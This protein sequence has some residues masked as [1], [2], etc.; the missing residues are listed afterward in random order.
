MTNLK[1]V[2]SSN[3]SEDIKNEP[4]IKQN[5]INNNLYTLHKNKTYIS[6]RS[7]EK[8]NSTEKNST[9]SIK[10]DGHK[11]SLQQVVYNLKLKRA[12]ELSVPHRILGNTSISKNDSDKERD[13]N[14]KKEENDDTRDSQIYDHNICGL[15][16]EHQDIQT[17]SLQQEDDKKILNMGKFIK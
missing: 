17:I 10:Y 15:I 6:I 16:K 9:H 12:S 13:N 14:T 7:V 3:N 11:N 4:N 1:S 8:N 2:S 5:I